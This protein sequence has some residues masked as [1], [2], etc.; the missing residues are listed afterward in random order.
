MKIITLVEDTCGNENCKHEHGLSIYIET[1]KHK[2]LVDTGATDAF[3]YNAKQLG[4]DLT[5]V[6]TVILSHGHYDHAGGIMAF[7]ELNSHAAIYMQRT[8][9]NDYYHA[10]RYIGIDKRIAELTNVRMLDGDYQIDDELFLF[11]NIT[12]RKYF[13]KSNLLLSKRVN[14]EQVQDQF[15]HEQCLVITQGSERTLISGCAHNGILNILDRYRELFDQDPR[16][17][18]S[19]FHMMKKGDYTQEE[20]DIICETAKKLC[21]TDIVFYTGHCTGDRAMKLMEPYLKDK[22]V[23]IH[24]GMLLYDHNGNRI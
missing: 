19:G 23:P 24:S 12:G 13:A 16:M 8:A 21:E 17:V 7:A 22:L 20:I 14:N 4:V 11:T 2:L 10:D 9:A 6:D 15:E 5:S 1:K 3:F 18:I